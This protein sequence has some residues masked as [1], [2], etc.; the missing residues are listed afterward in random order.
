MDI[1]IRNET[2]DQLDAALTSTLAR[3][4]FQKDGPELSADRFS[5]SYRQGY[6]RLTIMS[7]F[8]EGLKVGQLVCL[9]K[10]FVVDG[11][12]HLAAEF[13]DLFVSP[14]FRGFKVASS[15]YK[16]MQKTVVEA[17]AD[18]LF[19]YANEGASV[20]NRRFFGMEEVTQLP[21]RIGFCLP[22]PASS[23]RTGLAVLQNINDIASACAA[24]SGPANI[25]GV[26]LTREELLKRISSPVHQYLCATDGEIAILASPRI[27]RS[28]PLLLICATFSRRRGAAKKQATAEIIETLCRAAGRRAFLYLGWNDAVGFSNGLRVS[29]RLLK[30]KFLIQSNCLNSR[31]DGIGRFEILDVDY[32]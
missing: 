31:R 5:W 10:T 23:S 18:I 11:R 2:A 19:A 15:L 20:L 26:H 32:G 1:T 13:I 3:E 27:I 17:G 6:D 16:E 28:V 29:E 4:A 30:G 24:C 21:A 25:G 14:E 12:E 8:A 22:Y 9:F 7:A